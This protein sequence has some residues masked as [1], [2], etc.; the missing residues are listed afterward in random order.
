METLSFSPERLGISQREA[1]ERGQLNRN[2]LKQLVTRISITKEGDKYPHTYIFSPAGLGKT[3][4]VKAH[5]KKSNIRYIQVSGNVSMFAFGIQLAVINF[6]NPYNEQV[7]IFVDDCDEI[8]RTESSCN[9]MKN[10][11]DGAKTFTYEKSLSS[12][13]DNLT[14][15]QQEAIDFFRK[16]G[17]MGFTVPTDNL[18]FVF[19][20]NFKLP[21]DDEVRASRAKGQSKSALLAHKNAIRSRCRVADFDLSWKEHW[22]WIADVALNTE[23]LSGL[24]ITEKEVHV[25]LD[26]LWHHWNRLTERS[27]RL[28]EKMAETMKDYPKT[29]KVLW[30]IDYLKNV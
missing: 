7:V 1:L 10:V 24:E 22:G 8:F 6:L 17:K 3:Y 14:P 28:I 15:L 27:I 21:I 29:Y 30:E 20:S 19:T 23:C 2:R 18:I 13:W 11:L 26:F 25:I 16:E 9:T 4:A 5:L 12:Q